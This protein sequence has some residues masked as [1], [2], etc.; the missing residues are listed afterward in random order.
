V[1]VLVDHS[2]VESFA[3]GGRTA[4]KMRVYS[5][6]AIYGTARV[7]LFNNA[8]AGSVTARS[9][10]STRW[11]PPPITKTSSFHLQTSNGLV[12]SYYSSR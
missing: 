8:T 7:Y 2:I 6:K 10:L 1:R 4:V 5:T 3:M 9:S 11:T 12:N